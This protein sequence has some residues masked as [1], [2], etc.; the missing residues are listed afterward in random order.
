MPNSAKLKTKCHRFRAQGQGFKRIRRIFVAL[1]RRCFVFILAGFGTPNNRRVQHCGIRVEIVNTF[2][3]RTENANYHGPDHYVPICARKTKVYKIRNLHGTIF[4]TFFYILQPNFIIF[5]K[6]L[7][8]GEMQE[9]AR[10]CT[11]KDLT[12]PVR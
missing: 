3:L 12:V 5:E 7:Y 4:F 6:E 2:V 9:K 1:K 11:G 8:F 10:Q